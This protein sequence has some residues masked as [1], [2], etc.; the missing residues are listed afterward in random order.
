MIKALQFISNEKQSFD[1]N[2][3]LVGDNDFLYLFIKNQIIEKSQDKDEILVFDCTDKSD[4]LDQ[5]IGSLGSQDLFSNNNLI[6]V[7]NI[8]KLNKKNSEVLLKNIDSDNPHQILCIDNNFLS[9]DYKSKS[10]TIKSASTKEFSKKLNVIDISTPFESEMKQWIQL[11]ANEL[12]MKVSNSYSQKIIEIF[13]NNFSEIYNE[14]SKSSLT[15]SSEEDFI[16]SLENSSYNHKD[17]QLWELNYAICD[18][19]VDSIFEN[20]LS[21]MKQYGLSYLINSMF[22][23]I[24]AIFLTKKNNGTLLDNQ[25]RSIRG[26]LLKRITPATQKYSMEELEHAI[27]IFAQIDIKLKTKKIIDETEFA[28]IINGVFRSER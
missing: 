14:M 4:T 15:S 24:E 5:I 2:Y 16:T 18:R 9:Y 22:S 23:V 19:K 25:S 12:N 28:N 1:D 8:N 17:K 11:F 20:G 27:N 21:I 3:L 10:N 7:K 26:N 13:G 6:I